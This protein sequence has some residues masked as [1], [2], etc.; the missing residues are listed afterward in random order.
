MTANSVHS[1]SSVPYLKRSCVC[2]TSFISDH[3]LALWRP[4]ASHSRCTPQLP[5]RCPVNLSVKQLSSLPPIQITRLSPIRKPLLLALHLTQS[6]PWT[7]S[8]QT[9]ISCCLCASVFKQGSLVQ[10]QGRSQ[11]QWDPAP[12]PITGS[13][14]PVNMFVLLICRLLETTWFSARQQTKRWSANI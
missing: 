12:V 9:T 13:S 7:I 14:P 11:S 1:S 5:T 10:N 2:T 3:L 6:T 4:V 8:S